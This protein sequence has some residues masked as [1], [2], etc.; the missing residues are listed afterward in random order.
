MQQGHLHG[1]EGQVSGMNI[2]RSRVESLKHHR[3][4]REKREHI[5]AYLH[6]GT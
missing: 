4:H 6:S 2:P 5:S 3:H 1:I